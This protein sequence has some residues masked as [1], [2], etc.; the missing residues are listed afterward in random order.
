MDG[1]TPKP[2]SPDGPK[3]K[4]KKGGDALSKQQD[5]RENIERMRELLRQVKN[6]IS[7]LIHFLL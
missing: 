3:K 4:N 7:K 5:D 1:S 2:T 6:I